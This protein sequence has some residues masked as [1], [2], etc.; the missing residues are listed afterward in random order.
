M[1]RIIK[2]I[3]NLFF[4]ISFKNLD[5]LVWLLIQILPS[6]F[7]QNLIIK[8]PTLKIRLRFIDQNNNRV[9]LF[10]KNIIR[11][12][13]KPNFICSTC[14]SRAI[15]GRLILDF[16]NM[17]NILKLGLIINENGDKCPHAWLENPIENYEYNPGIK[18][19][20]KSCLIRSFN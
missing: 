8:R 19:E 12:S 13:S 10:F 14:L 4:F 20:R 16:F 5:I 1:I 11:K 15:T 2:Y 18:G 7:I 6:I 9:R 3:I 17:P